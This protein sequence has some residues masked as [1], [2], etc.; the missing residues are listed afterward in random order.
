[1]L[2]VLSQ[3][4]FLHLIENLNFLLKTTEM[5]LYAYAVLLMVEALFDEWPGCMM[6]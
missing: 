2:K 6:E 4:F 5:K 3:L 1:M